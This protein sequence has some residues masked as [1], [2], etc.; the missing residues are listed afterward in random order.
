ML[1]IALHLGL[2]KILLTIQ[3]IVQDRPIID[4]LDR[5]E[6][7]ELLSQ[8]RGQLLLVPFHVQREAARLCVFEGIIL[9]EHRQLDLGPGQQIDDRILHTICFGQARVF[10]QNFLFG[11]D[12]PL[13]LLQMLRKGFRI[14]QGKIQ[15]ILLLQIFLQ[16]MKRLMKA[17][18][19][20]RYICLQQEMAPVLDDVME[21]KIDQPHIKRAGLLQQRFSQMVDRWV[22]F[23]IDLICQC[24]FRKERVFSFYPLL[25]LFCK[26][27]FL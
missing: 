11:R 4:R 16:G 18:S 14:R 27:A 9:K 7:L 26:F 23:I 1:L 8:N 15:L 25:F 3:N 21:R 6:K 10:L 22:G 20:L 24:L 19:F 5:Q 2:R 17:L 13:P 12:R